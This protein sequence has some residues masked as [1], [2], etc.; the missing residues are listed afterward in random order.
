MDTGVGYC[1]AVQLKMLPLKNYVNLRAY[2]CLQKHIFISSS[3][4]KW[5]IFLHMTSM[6]HDID[7][8]LCIVQNQ[9]DIPSRYNTMPVMFYV[10]AGNYSEQQ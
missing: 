6:Q 2:L 9:H 4:Y 7:K 1:L 8:L 3:R 10:F 5:Y